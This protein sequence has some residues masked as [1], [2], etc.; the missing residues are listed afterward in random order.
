LQQTGQFANIVNGDILWILNGTSLGIY[1]ISTHTNDSV[2]ISGIFPSISYSGVY[3]KVTTAAS[4]ID[5]QPAFQAAINAANAAGGGIAYVPSEYFYFTNTSTILISQNVILQGMRS[6]PVFW[7][8]DSWLIGQNQGPVLLPTATSGA[9]FITLQGT[10]GTSTIEG[11]TIFYPFQLLSGATG[12]NS[13]SVVQYPW[14]IEFQA[15]HPNQNAQFCDNRAINLT[16]VNPY[17]GIKMEGAIFDNSIGTTRNHVHNIYGCPLNIGISIDNIEDVSYVEK[18]NFSSYNMVAYDPTVSSAQ[19]ID[20]NTY[21]VQHVTAIQVKRA[22]WLILEDIFALFAHCGILLTDDAITSG[23]TLMGNNIQFDLADVGIHVNLVNLINSYTEPILT[24]VRITTGSP[25]VNNP[26]IAYQI[27]HCVYGD[28]IANLGNSTVKITNASLL[29]FLGGNCVQW[30]IPGSLTISDALFFE[31]ALVGTSLGYGVA[32]THGRIHVHGCE[33]I[34]QFLNCFNITSTEP[35]MIYGNDY[36]NNSVGINDNM[37]SN[38]AITS[39][40]DNTETNFITSQT[41]SQLTLHDS[42]TLTAGLRLGYMFNAG[43]AEYGRIQAFDSVG[44]TPLAINPNG[45]N[46]GIGTTSSQ[47]LLQLGSSYIVAA[48]PTGDA[49]TDTASVKNAIAAVTSNVNIG[50]TVYLQRGVYVIN[51]TIQLSN[52][53]NLIGAATG[54]TVLYA[55]SVTPIEVIKIFQ[56][57]YVTVKNIRIDSVQSRIHTGISDKQSYF[58]TVENCDVWNMDVGLFL[59]FDIHNF[60]NCDFNNC[61]TGILL[62]DITD[63]SNNG[64]CSANN[65]SS[66]HISYCKVYGIHFACSAFNNR[67]FGVTIE[68]NW[69]PDFVAG[70]YFSDSTSWCSANILDGCYFENN[71]GCQIKIATKGNLFYGTTILYTNIQYISPAVDRYNTPITPGLTIDDP[72]SYTGTY[73][74]PINVKCDSSTTFIWSNDN[75]VTWSAPITITGTSQLLFNGVKIIFSS[76]TGHAITEEWYFWAYS[77]T[78]GITYDDINSTGEG[79]SFYGTFEAST[80]GGIVYKDV[81]LR[82]V[83]IGSTSIDPAAKLQVTGGDIKIA[84]SSKGV[85]MT[86]AAGTITKRVRLNDTGDGFVFENP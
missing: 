20:W 59:T 72:Y 57:A 29:N 81:L 39:V 56:T 27:L 11:L 73:S 49:N 62:G 4:T 80:V 7:R 48:A 83:S 25:Y 14:C 5:N 47:G 77:A 51:E 78:Q 53:L 1:I 21:I 16:L 9:S 15:G 3:W 12:G 58:S 30:D 85:I 18:I 79:N 61:N 74:C 44:P 45:G 28:A 6:S 71:D 55:N 33:F 65:F 69:G 84:T 17:N 64:W 34:S 35:N 10:D 32:A 46:V 52:S 76:T 40:A 24:N 19:W 63:V 43:V 38:L 22:D 66:C 23:A 68:A 2:I 50:A 82:S 37:N 75:Q 31:D 60:S 41:Y 13:F 67:L 86:N 54:T 42:D 8:K 70:V 36:N 26:T